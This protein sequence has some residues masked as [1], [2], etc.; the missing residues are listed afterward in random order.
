MLARTLTKLRRLAILAAALVTLPATAQAQWQIETKDGSATLKLGILA[1][2]QLETLETADG[3][4]TSA[5]LFFRRF[6]VLVGGKVADKWLYFFETDSPNLGKANP[7]RTANPTGAKDAGDVFIQDMYITYDRSV[8]FKV[9]LGMI[10]LPLSHNHM[11]SAATLLPVDYG[12]FTFVE[13]GP[14]GER[15]G[16]DYGVQLRGYPAKQKFE[17]R[18]GVFQG[19]RGVQATNALRVVGRAVYY[20]FGADTGF[21]YGGTWQ[22]TKKMLGVGASFDVQKDYKAGG[23]DLI[24]ERPLRGGAQGVTLQIDWTRTDGGTF[25]TALPKQDAFLLEAGY[26]LAKGRFTPFVQYTTHNFDLASTADQDA[27]QVGLASWLKGHNRNIK[28][29]IGRQH[30]SG[31]P[32]RMQALV[33]LQIFYY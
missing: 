31:G 29:S 12:A 2:P 5:N 6:R 25:V 8:A 9:D 32:N 28:A 17:Y 15:T 20:P 33:Q 1:Q 7:D 27:F 18:F 22:G 10:L 14:L 19:V 16:R 21:F 11:Q 30:T 26:H 3:K 23:A 13:S 4:D 24:Y